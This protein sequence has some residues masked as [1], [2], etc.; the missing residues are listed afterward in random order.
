MWTEPSALL[1][2]AASGRAMA[3]SAARGGYAVTVMDGFCDADTR[4]V[5]SCVAVPMDAGGLQAERVRGEAGRLAAMGGCIGFVYG[6]GLEHSPSTLAWMAEHFPLL[7]NAPEVLDL[8]RDPRRFFALLDELEIRYPQ[9]SVDPP[10]PIEARGWLVKEAGTSGGMGVRRWRDGGPRPAGE[11]YFQRFLDGPVMS[12]LFIADGAEC[13]I[14]GLNRLRTAPA[15]GISPF[16]YGGAVNQATLNPGQRA[17]VERYCADLVKA[18]GLRGFNNLDFVLHAGQVR[19][20]ELNPRPSATLG[21]YDRDWPGGWMRSH[22][23]ACLG[24]LPDAPPD[25]G[26]RVS[27]HRI[28]Y[29]PRAVEVPP[30]L[31]W[32][33]WCHDRPRGG[34]RV[35]CG[36]PLC[37][38]SASGGSAAETER[39][40][41]NRE[42][43]VLELM[44]SVLHEGAQVVP[45]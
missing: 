19:P 20:L 41:L 3:E 16:Q 18:L 11:H 43:G 7:G 12:A 36:A 38:V 2:V 9:T 30:Q 5:A 45:S 37:S 29:A 26:V 23:R 8:L 6:A 40:L 22:V 44:D 24:E 15:A 34:T 1:I 35:G 25:P 42:R 33:R 21:L 13:S 32:P 28:I 39:W 17:R 14:V 31:R 10:P 4:L 27:G